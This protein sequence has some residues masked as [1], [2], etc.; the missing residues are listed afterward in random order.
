MMRKSIT[1]MTLIAALSICSISSA[2]SGKILSNLVSQLID[3]R[4]PQAESHKKYNFT[5]P[6]DGWVFFSSTAAVPDG[7][8]VY[9]VVDSE[10][11]K[12]AV[13][14]HG[15][16]A[17]GR[18][19]GF[20][21]DREGMIP[22][23]E[24]MRHLPAGEHTLNVYCEGGASLQDLVIR[25]IP[26][27][28]YAETGYRPSRFLPS[29][30]PFT[31]EFLQRVGVT[32]NIN[33]VVERHPDPY[34]YSGIWRT[35]GKKIL[36]YSN[37]FWMPGLDRVKGADDSYYKYWISREGMVNDRYDGIILDE[38]GTGSAHLYPSQTRAVRSI[39][40]KPAFEDKMLYAY[41]GGLHGDDHSRAFAQAIFDAGYK[42]VEERYLAEQPTKAA[43]RESI[44]AR[45]KQN[46]LA[47]QKAFPGCQKDMIIC[48]GYMSA[49]PESHNTDPG[50]N[51]KVFL[52][53]QFN[54]IV[55]D[56]AFAGLYGIMCYHS[57]FADEEI[58]RWSAKLFRHYC[59]EGNRGMLSQDPYILPHLQNGDFAD[60]TKGWTILPAEKRSMDVKQFKRYSWLQGRYPRTKQGNT[61]LRTR[62]SA[63]GPN[64]FSQDIRALKPGRLYSL[65][66]FTADYQDLT[67]GRD[68]KQMHKVRI[69]IDDVDLLPGK[70]FQDVFPSGRAGHSHGKFD[71]DNN[72]WISYHNLVFRARGESAAL[73]VSDWIADDKP[74]GE[75]GQELIFNFIEIQPYLE[76]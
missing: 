56:P 32:D 41:C 74:G 14:L 12:K 40:Q 1:C 8:N 19:E 57:A 15:K 33:V 2:D 59:I 20:N 38:F 28:L 26:E 63:K 29:Y 34:M 46:M 55:N 49:P 10:N 36:E 27:I 4:G 6:K 71:R 13:T 52:D 68:V 75:I 58:L 37:L 47:Y 39:S 45:I 62:R 30:T 5:N 61:F 76:D 7:G 67:R 3:F 72:L 44:E 51:Y 50:V 24:A 66:M 42:L 73:T 60:G 69:T 53:M 70:C 18:T 21:A 43:A 64:R 65:K 54:A 31:W 17:V 9:L 22:V 48:L 23:K 25:S 16:G 11:R 35:Q